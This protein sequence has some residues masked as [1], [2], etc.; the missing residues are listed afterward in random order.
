MVL[1]VAFRG[2]DI[3]REGDVGSGIKRVH[4]GK[5]KRGKVAEYAP[6]HLRPRKK[7]VY[8]RERFL[9]KVLKDHSSSEDELTTG[10]L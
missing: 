2:S 5:M 4:R 7:E 6:G 3:P 8:T 9:T 1:S 10:G